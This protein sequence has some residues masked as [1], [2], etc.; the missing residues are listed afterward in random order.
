LNNN[1]RLLLK[2]RETHSFSDET[3]ITY[4]DTNT[5]MIFNLQNTT[6]RTFNGVLGQELEQHD[7][8]QTIN[9]LDFLSRKRYIGINE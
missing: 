5:I 1:N 9:S 2:N 8:F 3:Q 6:Q 4:G 7:E